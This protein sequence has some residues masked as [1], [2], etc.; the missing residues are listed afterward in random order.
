MGQ[1]TIFITYFHQHSFASALISISATLW[2]QYI[3][4]TCTTIT[5]LIHTGV[6]V[7]KKLNC[8]YSYNSRH[9][10]QHYTYITVSYFTHYY[11]HVCACVCS[12]HMLNTNRRRRRVRMGGV[13]MSCILRVASLLQPQWLQKYWLSPVRSSSWGCHMAQRER[14]RGRESRHTPN[15]G[16]KGAIRAWWSYTYVR[17]SMQEKCA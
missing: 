4:T 7:G 5:I 11:I 17:V 8:I 6:L 12:A 9:Y 2:V 1:I 3:L 10:V 14:E 15:W 13:D 16:D